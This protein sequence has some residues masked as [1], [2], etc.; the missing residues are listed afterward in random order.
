MSLLAVLPAAPSAVLA[1][2]R[3]VC[4]L[5]GV[6]GGIRYGSVA[7]RSGATGSYGRYSL[8]PWRSPPSGTLQVGGNG[9]VGSE[10]LN[11]CN[12]GEISW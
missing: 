10:G 2:T 8:L 5:D 1:I 12:Y 9:E 6:G 3:Y 11:L 7:V 4:V